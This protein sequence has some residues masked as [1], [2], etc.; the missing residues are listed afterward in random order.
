MLAKVGRDERGGAAV[1]IELH[2]TDDLQ[3]A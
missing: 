1:A 3:A 2:R